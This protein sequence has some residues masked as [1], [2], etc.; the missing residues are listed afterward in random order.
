[1][2]GFLC[3]TTATTNEEYKEV[4]K[5]RCKLLGVIGLIGVLT[6]LLCYFVEKGYISASLSDHM[7]GFYTGAGSGLI[8]VSLVLII[9]NVRTMRNE[10]MLKKAR[11]AVSD[12]RILEI[13]KYS[14]RVATWIMLIAFYAVAFIGGLWYPILPQ[15]L[16][17]LVCVLLVSYC[18]CYWVMSKKM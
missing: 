4:L 3:T 6:E 5:K 10:E 16:G 1:M 8:A 15:I 12:E 14:F 7:L 17:L 9:K 11:I 2:K 18:I 13:S